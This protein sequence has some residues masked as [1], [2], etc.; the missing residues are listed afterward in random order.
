MYVSS[1][2]IYDI[3]E[4][5]IHSQKIK[6]KIKIQRIYYIGKENTEN[7]YNLLMKY[8]TIRHAS[9]VNSSIFPEKVQTVWKGGGGDPGNYGHC[10]NNRHTQTMVLRNGDMPY[11]NTILRPLALIQHVRIL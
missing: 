9:L 5:F 7:R 1:L 6:I 8:L 3:Y 10:R 11:A 2:T 4:R